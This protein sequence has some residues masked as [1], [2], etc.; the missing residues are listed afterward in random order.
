MKVGHIYKKQRDYFLCV[1]RMEIYDGQWLDRTLNTLVDKNMEAV[2]VY[3]ESKDYKK[4]KDM[5]FVLDK[6]FLKK[7]VK[8]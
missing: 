6:E 4:Y 8:R 7:G 3:N 5:G 2:Y 1:N